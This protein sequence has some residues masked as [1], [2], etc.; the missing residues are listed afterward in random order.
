MTYGSVELELRD[1]LSSVDL[2]AIVQSE[3]SKDKKFSLFEESPE[4]LVSFNHRE[5]G[6]TKLH[7]GFP[8][9]LASVD[10]SPTQNHFKLDIFIR[11]EPVRR[12]QREMLRETASTYQEIDCDFPILFR[13]LVGK[14]NRIIF[15]DP[16]QFIG[17]S[18][19]GLHFLDS[20]SQGLGIPNSIVFS[21][22]H[23][24]LS[25]LVDAR[26]Y[27]PVL[28]AK[29]VGEGDL[30]VAPD[31]IDSHWSKTLSVIDSLRDK[32]LPMIIPGRSLALN[33]ANGNL[34]VYHNNIEDILLT[35][36]NVEDYMNDCLMA[37]GISGNAVSESRKYYD[38]FRFF[39][40]PFAS[41]GARYISPQLIFSVYKSLKEADK[42]SE[43]YLISDYHH[44]PAHITWLN[45]FLELMRTDDSMRRVSINYYA[46]LD[47]LVT[48]MKEK[49]C[50]AVLTADTSIAHVANR[51]GYS[52]VTIYNRA[53]WDHNSLQS[54]SGSSPL[55]FCRYL[56]TQ[57]PVINDPDS[58]YEIKQV[59]EL[60][61]DA[62]IFSQM[63]SSNQRISYLKGG[64]NWID[65][66]YN[67]ND[68]TSGIVSN[69][70]S[71]HLLSAAKKISLKHKLGDTE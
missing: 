21:Q 16:Y 71:V 60:I 5:K 48:H 59:S 17:D 66:L 58:H 6:E 41:N 27:D 37:F 19:I 4:I 23:Q 44:N 50:G 49:E 30:I 61:R 7:V 25:G 67:S 8:F 22:Q 70:K 55:G 1:R 63:T 65:A 15:L 57:V 47:E 62:M 28:V 14:Q 29:E 43:F 56:R 9:P 24:H 51:F 42:K 12:I 11:G 68:I 38:T 69:A 53:F 26:S 20:F 54:M 10:Y 40:N 34:N 36:K 35:N 39:L 46:N 2:D 33:F 52:C 13:K 18:F 45:R 64:A 31:L 32:N 3:L